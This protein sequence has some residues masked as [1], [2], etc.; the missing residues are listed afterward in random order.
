M[1]EFQKHNCKQHLKTKSIY[2]K[3][4]SNPPKSVLQLDLN[5]EQ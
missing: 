5:N 1:I 4:K 3:L 2:R